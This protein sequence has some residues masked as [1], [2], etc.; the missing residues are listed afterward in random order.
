MGITASFLKLPSQ[1]RFEA[2]FIDD[3][4]RQG[5]SQLTQ[6]ASLRSSF[7][8]FVKSGLW[9]SSLHETEMNKTIPGHTIWSKY[10]YKKHC[11]AGD[12]VPA[13]NTSERTQ[14]SCDVSLY[15]I[16]ETTERSMDMEPLTLFTDPVDARALIVVLLYPIFKSANTSTDLSGFSTSFNGNHH[17]ASSCSQQQGN[18]LQ[19]ILLSLAAGCDEADLLDYLADPATSVTEDYLRALEKLPVKLMV[20]RVEQERNELPVLYSNFQLNTSTKEAM[21]LPLLEQDVVGQDLHILYGNMCSPGGAQLLERAVF[22]GKTFK[23]SL[24]LPNRRCKLLAFCPI[25]GTS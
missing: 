16:S 2:I 4:L 10:G 12:V 7:V 14:V 17:H 6:S 3:A 11:Q 1:Q 13:K 15:A 18:R 25:N 20:G 5:C 23:K 21:G 22:A 24:A 19:E 9:E 8:A